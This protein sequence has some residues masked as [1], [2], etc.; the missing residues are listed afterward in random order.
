MVK[1]AKENWG[2]VGIQE[3]G[4]DERRKEVIKKMQLR[5]NEANA[6]VHTSQ[7]ERGN[8]SRSKIED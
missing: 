5:T 6:W 7:A 1:E 3:Y 8:Q 2:G 4:S